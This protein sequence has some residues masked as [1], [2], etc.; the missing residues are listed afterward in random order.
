MS[1]CRFIIGS[2]TQAMKAKRILS[3]HSI[4]TEVAKF[5]NTQNNT[6]CTYGIYFRCEHQRNVTSLLQKDNIPFEEM[7]NDIS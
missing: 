6:G 4:A 5:G 2:V 7:K 1:D 3:A